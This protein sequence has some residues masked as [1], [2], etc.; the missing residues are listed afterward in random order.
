MNFLQVFFENLLANKMNLQLFTRIIC[1]RDKKLLFFKK[2]F[3]LYIY[4]WEIILYNSKDIT[5]LRFMAIFKV[6]KN[7]EEL[8][9]V[10]ES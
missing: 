3:K 1:A 2:N 5:K 6:G 10:K 8:L 7:Q 9:K 4:K